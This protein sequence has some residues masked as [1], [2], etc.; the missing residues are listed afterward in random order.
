MELIYLW[1]EEYKNI[2]NQGFNF[3]PRFECKYENNELSICD[4]KK[5]VCKDNSYIDNFFGDNINIT[6]IVG[7]NGSG[8]SALSEALILG[9]SQYLNEKSEVK[10]FTILENN[11]I[12]YYNKT[13]KQKMPSIKK[14]EL[15]KLEDEEL[16]ILHSSN[17]LDSFS[18]ELCDNIQDKTYELGCDFI[19][20]LETTPKQKNFFSF[21]D[22]SKNIIN[23][24]KINITVQR[25]MLEIIYNKNHKI[26]IDKLKK[27][28]NKFNWNNNSNINFIPTQYKLK[29]SFKNNFLKFIKEKKLKELAKNYYNKI[30]KNNDSHLNLASLYILM[31]FYEVFKLND[32]DYLKSFMHQDV[33]EI[34]NNFKK[35]IDDLPEEIT[36]NDIDKFHQY[37]YNF[38][39]LF[40]NSNPLFN[41]KELP[42]L[43]Y[44]IYKAMDYLLYVVHNKN[45]TFNKKIDIDKNTEKLLSK[46]PYFIDMELFTTNNDISFNSLCYG[47]KVIIRM[48]YN[49]LAYTQNISRKEFKNLVII[50]DEI[51]NGL[52]P[53]WQKIFIDFMIEVSKF[54][55]DDTSN[56]IESIHFIPITHSPF[57]LSDLPKDNIL[58]LENGKQTKGIEKKQTFG[59]N[60]HTLLSD[61]FFMEDGLM[62]EFAKNKIKEIMDFLNND[63]DIKYF[64]ISQQQIKLIIESIGE[65]LLRMKLLDMYYEKFEKDELEKEKQQL[66][67]KQKEITKVIKSIEEKQKK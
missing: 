49:L 30:E 58:F 21:P 24:K 52:N 5:R 55:I 8:K 39:L 18:D 38:A 29:F 16:F 19:Y 54:I 61:S 56:T 53:S 34:Y 6:A 51:E 63:K 35:L 65:D 40:K 33:I 46:L 42:K 10:I 50:F 43:F 37:L 25:N 9:L 36:V 31:R 28:F 47:E 26:N 1:V 27:I 44:D 60:I 22:K 3:S 66:L 45:P 59:A 12:Y 11:G 41:E 4:K 14:K 17:S 64:D 2:K 57:I 13:D 7:K 67:E 20:D 62:G 32:D 15:K 23:L 48:F